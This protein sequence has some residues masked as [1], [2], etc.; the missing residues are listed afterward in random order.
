MHDRI[1]RR[2][3]KEIL[4]PFAPAGPQVFGIRV[5][6]ED[7]DIAAPQVFQLCGNQPDKVRLV[8][9]AQPKPVEQL[10]PVEAIS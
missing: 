10:I 6:C 8:R 1:H 7:G 9:G 2:L 4:N 3:L 5:S